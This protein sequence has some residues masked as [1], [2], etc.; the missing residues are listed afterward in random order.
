M[1]TK[2]VERRAINRIIIMVSS[3]EKNGTNGNRP[4]FDVSARSALAL[5]RSC[6]NHH[7]YH[8]RPTVKTL[9]TALVMIR[10]SHTA[11]GELHLEDPSRLKTVMQ[12]VYYDW[13]T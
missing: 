4:A 1:E 5:T 7:A 12:L 8:T 10:P 2:L 3:V 9:R 11:T 13:V 6:C